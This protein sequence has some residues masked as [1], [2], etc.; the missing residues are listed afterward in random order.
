MLGG[1]GGSGGGADGGP[2][3]LFVWSPGGNS[4]DSIA[5]GA[6]GPAGGSGMV[7]GWSAGDILSGA[8]SLAAGLWG[9][10]FRGSIGDIEAAAGDG[11]P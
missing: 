1:M 8:C 7:N 3:V 6:A 2:A 5:G 9:C 4:S 10:G 11:M